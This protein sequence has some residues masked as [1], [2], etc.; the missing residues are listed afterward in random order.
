MVRKVVK[1]FEGCGILEVKVL[2]SYVLMFVEKIRLIKKSI[3][4]L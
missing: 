4:Y 1:I 3:F 2:R